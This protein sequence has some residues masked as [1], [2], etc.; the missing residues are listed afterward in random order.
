MGRRASRNNRTLN[1]NCNIEDFFFSPP[2]I[3]PWLKSARTGQTRA[4]LY[5]L[6]TQAHS[7]DVIPSAWPL[8]IAIIRR[9]VLSSPRD[10][11]FFGVLI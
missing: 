9:D 3:Q 4:E 2:I 7:S 1:R 10:I 5:S 8:W 6:N 11:H